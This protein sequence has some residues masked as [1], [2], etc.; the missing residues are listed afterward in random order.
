MLNILIGGGKYTLKLS[1]T[2]KSGLLIDET[3]KFD[4][5]EFSTLVIVK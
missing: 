4:S 2:A 1:K 5:M 3:V